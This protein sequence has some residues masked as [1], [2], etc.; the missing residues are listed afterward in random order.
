MIR[1]AIACILLATGMARA[2]ELT[3]K[4]TYTAQSLRD[5]GIA[6]V[7]ALVGDYATANRLELDHSKPTVFLVDG[8][9]VQLSP[10]ERDA[11]LAEAKGVDVMSDGVAVV[12][13]VHR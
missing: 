7:P 5:Q 2:G 1:V 8:K 11:A 13:D 10:Q 6:S 12:V 4:T 9:Y 3:H